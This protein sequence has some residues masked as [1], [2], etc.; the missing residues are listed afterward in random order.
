[1]YFIRISIPALSLH[2]PW[3]GFLCVYA[4]LQALSTYLLLRETDLTH[5]FNAMRMSHALDGSS[6]LCDYPT[7]SIKH[8]QGKVKPP[9]SPSEVEPMWSI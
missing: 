6:S 2:R 9:D 4:N 3:N 5:I 1:M 8:G 7:H